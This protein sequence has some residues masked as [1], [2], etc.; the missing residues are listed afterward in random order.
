[1]WGPVRDKLLSLILMNAEQ[2]FIGIFKSTNF[3]SPNQSKVSL[4]QCPYFEK[5]IFNFGV[6]FLLK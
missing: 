4:E 3:D 1:M 6:S 2:V 5:P